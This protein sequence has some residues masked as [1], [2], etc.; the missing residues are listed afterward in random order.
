MVVITATTFHEPHYITDPGSV[1][2]HCHFRKGVWFRFAGYG[3]SIVKSTIDNIGGAY[4]VRAE[5]GSDGTILRSVFRGSDAAGVLVSGG[6]RVVECDFTGR[7]NDNVIQAEGWGGG[8]IER[9]VTDLDDDGVGNAIVNA[10]HASHG[11]SPGMFHLDGCT[12]SGRR[13]VIVGSA[14][15]NVILTANRVIATPSPSGQQFFAYQSWSPGSALP[16]HHAGNRFTGDVVIDGHV[17][18]GITT[19]PPIPRVGRAIYG[20]VE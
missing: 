3:S 8:S 1:Y 15:A 13:C 12:I 2:V 20:A 11:E 9:C 14:A 17:Y 4:A 6:L 7:W 19:E 18:A 5:P 16:A 10:R